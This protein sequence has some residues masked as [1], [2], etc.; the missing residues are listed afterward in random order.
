MVEGAFG[1]EGSGRRAA[2]ERLGS[3]IGIED[4]GGCIPEGACAFGAEGRMASIGPSGP[5]CQGL[6]KR[7]GSLR[8]GEKAVVGALEKEGAPL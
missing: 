7:V 1:R 6:Y 8:S 4:R 2:A 3:E 5:R